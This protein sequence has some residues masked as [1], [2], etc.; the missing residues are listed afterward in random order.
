MMRGTAFWEPLV[1]AVDSLGVLP[2]GLGADLW[3]TGDWYVTLVPA[4][5]CRT[6]GG[7]PCGN[8]RAPGEVPGGSDVLVGSRL[9]RGPVQVRADVLEDAAHDRAQEEQGD[10]H[11]DG[12]EGEEQTVLD[13]RLALLIVLAELREKSADVAA[14]EEKHVLRGPPFHEDWCRQCRGRV[15]H[16]EWAD[17]PRPPVPE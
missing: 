7:F 3:A 6:R 16:V 15:G 8:N 1:P 9:A 12:D 5:V 10:D 14:D 17:G 11:D 2:R 13:E 4:A